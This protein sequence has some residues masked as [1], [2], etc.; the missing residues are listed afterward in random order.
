[1]RKSI[2][3]ILCGTLLLSSTTSCGLAQWAVLSDP[4][5]SNSTKGAVVGAAS[6][7][8]TGSFIG[9]LLGNSYHSSRDNSLIGAAVG[10]VAGAAIGSAIGSDMD[11]KAEQRSSATAD[12]YYGGD[13]TYAYS[14]MP[15]RS[16]NCIYYGESKTKLDGSAKKA[17]DRVAKKLVADPSACAE[18]YGYT[19][20]AG[21]YSQ[22]CRLSVERAQV[23]KAY[24]V[25]KGVPASQIFCKGMAD[26]RQVA[27]NRTAEGRALN[28]RVEVVITHNADS[29]YD[30]PANGWH[31]SA[32]QTDTPQS[33]GNSNAIE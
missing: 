13:D 22:R 31:F 32:P 10:A 8:S 6:G 29:G 18:I 16:D 2:L 20:N 3:T 5:A 21:T 19:D 15:R 12:Y 23:V 24:L 33:Y 30:A 26:Q 1:M 25:K 9:S 17:L 11:K 28:R 4:D 7:A 27:D 14:S